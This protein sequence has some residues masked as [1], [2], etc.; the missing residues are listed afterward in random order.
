M[1]IPAT[2]ALGILPFV[3]ALF[4]P[5]P[6]TLALMFAAGFVFPP[7]ALAAGVFVDLL[8]YAGGWPQGLVAGATIAL[9]AHLV[10]QFVRAR[11]M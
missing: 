8:Y 6:L 10:R 2:I 1:R 3:S 5:Y 7:L 9:V 11:I 4:F